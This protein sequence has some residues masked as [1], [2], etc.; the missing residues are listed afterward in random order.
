MAMIPWT[1]RSALATLRPNLES[2]MEQFFRTGLEPT[3]LPAALTGPMPPINLAE[4]E[5]EFIATIELPG[6]DEKDIEVQVLGDQ[7]VVS[8]ER[9][10]E[11]EK[12][13]K[14][15]YRVESQYGTFRRTIELPTTVVTDADAIQATFSKGIL[16]IR[17][18]KTEKK[19]IGKIKVKAK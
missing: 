7:L 5:K 10:W 19:P 4:T 17:M 12:K 11:Q 9:K 6:M 1:E 14:E 18:P 13:D 2:W 8:G 15:F 3:R 16:E